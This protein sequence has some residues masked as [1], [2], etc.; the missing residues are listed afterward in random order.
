MTAQCRVCTHQCVSNRGSTCQ[1]KDSQPEIH[2][3]TCELGV[4]YSVLVLEHE[5]SLVLFGRQQIL[6]IIMVGHIAIIHVCSEPIV[7]SL[8][9]KITMDDQY[10]PPRSS[11]QYAFATSIG[12]LMPP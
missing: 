3:I 5:D 6:R 8:H 7:S 10:N 4:G 1:L 9:T 12:A 2:Y 11:R